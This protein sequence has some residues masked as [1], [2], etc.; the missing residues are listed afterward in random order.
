VLDTLN[1]WLP[2]VHYF[3][4][5]NLTVQP[6]AINL[7]TG[8]K[9]RECELL[10]GVKG[11]KAYLNTDKYNFQIITVGREGDYYPLSHVHFSVPKVYSGNAE[12]VW[13]CDEGQTL[14]AICQVQEGLA[15]QGVKAD[16]LDTAEISRFDTF[17]NVQ[18]SEPFQAYDGVFQL[19]KARQANQ[20]DYGST[21]LV[22]NKSQEF[23]VYDKV[24]ELQ[25]RH[26][27]TGG[28]PELV[29]FE[30]RL[31]KKRKV[32]SLLGFSSVSDMFNGG[33]A[34]IKDKRRE[35]WREALFRYNPSEFEHLATSEVL[36]MMNAYYQTGSR[37]WFSQ[38][39]KHFGMIT[40]V[41]SFGFEVIEDAIWR[42][43][44][45]D[46]TAYRYVKELQ[47]LENGHAMNELVTNTKT[48]GDLYSELKQKV[49][50]CEV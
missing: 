43:G 9:A 34:V 44:I 23:C 17:V 40:A 7:Q 25:N 49:L 41:Q 33:W 20:R 27:N 16:L 18:T 29:R 10:P 30:H 42:C 35:S 37:N 31:L 6:S 1:L 38:Y 5:A 45:P 28:L 15:N 47:E 11:S 19:L 2:D 50:E 39:W 32:Q 4:K 21:Y 22:H 46:R 12:N 48:M 13:P 36:A 24:Q 14:D 26:L 8:E 3:S